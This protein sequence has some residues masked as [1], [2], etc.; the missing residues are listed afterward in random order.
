M[1]DLQPVDMLVKQVK[2][3]TRFLQ[4]IFFSRTTFVAVGVLISVFLIAAIST[5]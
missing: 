5:N 3:N 4:R 2:G 1:N